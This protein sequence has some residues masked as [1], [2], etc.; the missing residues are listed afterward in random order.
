MAPNIEISAPLLLAQLLKVV[1]LVDHL[2]KRRTSR[3]TMNREFRSTCPGWTRY[4]PESR[5]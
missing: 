1:V 3:L 5:M 4:T 2:V